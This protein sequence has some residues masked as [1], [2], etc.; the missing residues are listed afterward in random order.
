[1]ISTKKK[2]LVSYHL[3]LLICH[4]DTTDFM[5]VECQ[6]QPKPDALEECGARRAPEALCASF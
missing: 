1:M 6:F 3:T 4:L 5:S 2:S